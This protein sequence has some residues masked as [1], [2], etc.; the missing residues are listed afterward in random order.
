MNWQRE[1]SVIY[2]PVPS[3]NWNQEL[4]MQMLA[5][6][7]YYGFWTYY[8]GTGDKQTIEDVYPNVRKY[9]HV[10]KIDE[11]GL[12]IPRKGGWT[13]GDWGDNKDLIL[14]YNAWYS[15][16]L[17]G[18][19]KMALLVGEKKDAE[20]ASVVNAK[21]KQAFHHH[22]WN[23]RYYISPEYNGLPD[24][25]AQALAVLAGI[26]PETEYETIRPFF[27]KYYNA[28]PYMEKY[29]L[30]SLCTMGFGEDAL[31]R[32]K[33]RY[34]DMVESP[35]TTLW[36][37]WGIGNEGFGGGS[38]NHAWSGGPLDNTICSFFAGNSSFKAWF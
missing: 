29:V 5:S 12:V 11:N 3:G 21:L 4:P 8:L 35:L 1:D 15:L 38:Y 24:D 33:I 13:W 16:A 17:K 34:K 32:M 10:W 20:W 14:L 25:R 37:G 26:L 27:T 31:H 30:E 19:E 23:G 18:F 6:V 22:F 36:E 9:I 28:S 7:G 2:A